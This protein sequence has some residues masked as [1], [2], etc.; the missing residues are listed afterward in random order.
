MRY[1][2]FLNTFGK[3]EKIKKTAYPFSEGAYIFFHDYIYLFSNVTP[4]IP[5]VRTPCFK[6]GKVQK[7]PG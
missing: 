4:E 5:L 6:A 1:Q 2:L 7:S 3:L